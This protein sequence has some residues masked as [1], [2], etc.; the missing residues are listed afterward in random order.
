[1]RT[2]EEKQVEI[3]AD[4]TTNIMTIKTS[5][6]NFDVN[7]IAASEYV[8]LPEIP[9]ENKVTIDIHAFSKGIE[10]VEYAVTEKNFSP[11]LTGVLLKYSQELGDKMTFVGTDSFRL[12]EFK[13]N[14]SKHEKDFSLIIPKVSITDVQ[15]I[16]EYASSK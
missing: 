13:A 14:S 4:Q 15:K 8:A 10:K 2:I 12:A 9:Q 6:D 5:K 16:A 11:V 1:M 3:S 7:G